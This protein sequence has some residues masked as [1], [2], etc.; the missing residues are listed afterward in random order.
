MPKLLQ[1]KVKLHFKLPVNY[2]DGKPIPDQ[3]I[4]DVKN[5]FV[6]RYGGLSVDSP[7]V[8]YWEENGFVYK[9]TNLEYSIFIAK[10][11]FDREVRKEIPKHIEKFKSDF[12][13]LAILCYYYPVMAT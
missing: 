3:A 5:F 10:T 4:A 12:K 8:G 7:P 2:N 11:R 13:Q 1:K 6:D 9:D